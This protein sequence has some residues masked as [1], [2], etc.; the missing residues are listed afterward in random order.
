MKDWSRSEVEAIVDDYL[1]MLSME[2]SC[3]PYNK[4]RHRRQL[5]DKL[6]G[7][8]EGSIEFKHA[9]ISAAL[10]DAG[11]AYI[12]GYL[13]RPNYQLLLIEVINDRLQ[14]NPKI[15]ELASFDADRPTV[16]PEVRDILSILT[17]GPVVKQSNPSKT[18]EVAV[19]RVWTPV[20]YMERESC[21]RAL[22][23]AG[24]ALILRYEQERLSREGK[25]GLAAKIEHTSK[26]RGDGA[27]YDI[28]SYEVT[29]RERLIEVKTTKHGIATPFFVT[30][31]EV[32]VSRQ[33]SNQY[34][35]YRLFNFQK[36]PR[37]YAIAGAI[38]R[39][40][41][42]LPKTYMAFPHDGI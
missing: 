23:E 3:V 22:G 6:N 28:L 19:H 40:C 32:A 33:H 34:Q 38:E 4:T 26:V 15:F 37:M 27:G 30:S 35:V 42:L 8:S 29:G 20:N 18:E 25:E 24:E 14:K 13:P 7:R 41:L 9:N 12:P 2:L 39:S 31:N 5:R 1:V 36:A 11:L 10:R 16:A 21:N 17:K